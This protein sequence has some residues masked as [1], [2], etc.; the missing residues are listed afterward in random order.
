[1][2]P[3][4][5]ASGGLVTSRFP[6]YS[7]ALRTITFS[8]ATRC[9]STYLLLRKKRSWCRTSGRP[10]VSRTAVARRAT[11]TDG[12]RG[13]WTAWRPPYDRGRCRLSF[14]FGWREDDGC[15]CRSCGHCT[16]DGPDRKSW[17][18]SRSVRKTRRT[19]D[20]QSRRTH[21]HTVHLHAVYRPRRHWSHRYDYTRTHAHINGYHHHYHRSI[22][23]EHD[24]Q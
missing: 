17:R 4:S 12:N 14:V 22:R 13:P 9:T 10:A 24:R 8:E 1:M 11:V 7:R 20:T 6:S 23:S 15:A 18:K 2:P 19:S 16:R 21:M 5:A 3:P